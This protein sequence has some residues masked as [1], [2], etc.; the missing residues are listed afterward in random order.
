MSVNSDG[1]ILDSNNAEIQDDPTVAAI[2]AA[3][4]PTDFEQLRQDTAESKA[5]QVPGWATW[6]EAEALDW[7]A[8]NVEP[9]LSSIAPKTLQMLSSMARLII[10]LR[11]RAMPGL[12]GQQA[13]D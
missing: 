4:D 6:T 7:V 3:H 12:R 11:D 8:T 13:D 10:V 2:V 5:E 1:I 9:E